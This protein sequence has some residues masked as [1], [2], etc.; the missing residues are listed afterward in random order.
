[1][2]S[3]SPLCLAL[4]LVASVAAHNSTQMAEM[5]ITLGAG[6]DPSGV[7]CTAFSQL[8]TPNGTQLQP[9]APDITGT[10]DLMKFCAADHAQV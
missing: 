8:F 6:A 2:V 1:M 9:G 7:N 3:F 4:A 5:Y 10:T